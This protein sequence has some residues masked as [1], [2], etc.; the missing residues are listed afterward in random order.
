MFSNVLIT[1]LFFN[2]LRN[3]KTSGEIALEIK[4]MFLLSPQLWF[5]T[6]FSPVKI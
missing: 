2:Y 3:T 1:S 4:Y 5:E 6:F